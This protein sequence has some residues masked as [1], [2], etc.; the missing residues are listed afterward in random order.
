MVY[1]HRGAHL[2]GYGN[3]LAANM[4]RH[5]VLLWTLPMFHCNGWCFPWSLSVQAGTHVCLR[6][7]RAGA[8]YSAMAEHGVTH[9]CGAPMVMQTILGASDTERKALSKRVIFLTA[10]APPP[11]ATL[12]AM[13]KEGFE[14]VHVYGLTEVYGPAVVNEWHGAWDELDETA[15][16]TM[17][18]RQG[19]RYQPLEALSVLD[20]KTMKPVPADG[21][22]LGEVMFRGNIVMKRDI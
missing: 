22:T 8:I 20:P 14:V 5:P 6:W 1:H 19:V 18:A 16:A 3:V 13:A 12:A 10:A 2:M 17:K 7:V 11:E 4:N 15:R 21:Q 9:L